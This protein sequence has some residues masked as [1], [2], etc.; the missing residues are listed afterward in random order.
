MRLAA[1]VFALFVQLSEAVEVVHEVNSLRPTIAPS[2]QTAAFGQ[3][4]SSAQQNV[5]I[6]ERHVNGTTT[7]QQLHI[8]GTTSLQFTWVNMLDTPAFDKF[9]EWVEIAFMAGLLICGVAGLYH[10][11]REC[12]A[13]RKP[14][15]R[16][17]EVKVTVTRASGDDKLGLQISP[18]DGESG[19]PMVSGVTAGYPA[20]GLLLEGDIVL[21]I[22]GTL[23][24][25]A[26]HAGQLLDFAGTSIVFDVVREKAAV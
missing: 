19:M 22:D 1:F 16:A 23:A 5:T 3:A 6:Q 7:V 9:K 20:D 17:N 21:S 14:T 4:A 10:L 12:N 15:A 2:V 8:N 13:T 24:Q 11:I 25:S 26:A 18:V